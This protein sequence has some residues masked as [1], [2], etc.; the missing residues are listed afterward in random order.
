M[1]PGSQTLSSVDSQTETHRFSF[2]ES[3][4]IIGQLLKWVQ[5]LEMSTTK[6][7]DIKRMVLRTDNF[8]IGASGLSTRT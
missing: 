4:T 8:R 3:K 7:T 5:G 2:L 1:S 6:V